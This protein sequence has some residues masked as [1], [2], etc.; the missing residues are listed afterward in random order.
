MCHGRYINIDVTK[1]YLNVFQHVKQINYGFGI[2]IQVN[3]MKV[4]SE[5]GLSVGIIQ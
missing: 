1:N 5:L 4:N 3:I 2:F